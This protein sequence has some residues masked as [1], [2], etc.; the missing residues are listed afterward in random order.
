MPLEPLV[1]DRPIEG[2]VGEGHVGHGQVLDLTL[3][4]AVIHG[5]VLC[6]GTSQQSP[7]LLDFLKS[8]PQPGDGGGGVTKFGNWSLVPK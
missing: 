7:D 2:E 8:L 3:F 6:R 5:E 4:V 1:S